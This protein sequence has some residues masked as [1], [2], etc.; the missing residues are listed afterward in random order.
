MDEGGGERDKEV[1]S[2]GTFT[3]SGNIC[4][5]YKLLGKGVDAILLLSKI[6]ITKKAIQTLNICAR[7][8]TYTALCIQ[9]KHL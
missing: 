5:S 6:G 7:C 2:I 1:M 8:L 4:T 3:I 9:A